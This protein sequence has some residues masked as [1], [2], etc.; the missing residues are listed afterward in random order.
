VSV[1]GG[2]TWTA[3]NVSENY[4]GVACSSDGTVQYAVTNGG[5]IYVSTDSGTSWTS[6]DSARNWTGVACSGDGT[7]AFATE[8]TYIYKSSDTG[9]TWT[10]NT[11]YGG[12]WRAIACSSS[13]LVVIAVNSTT[14]YLYY[15]GTGGV[16]YSL[17][18]NTVAYSAVATNTTGATGL[19]AA[20]PGTLYVGLLQL[21]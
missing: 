19:A 9:V 8:G 4:T 18:G 7:I 11:A 3:T 17:S 13:A 21:L 20:N 2:G 14:G 1:D 16:E 12:A 15:S 5:T 6:R 10:P